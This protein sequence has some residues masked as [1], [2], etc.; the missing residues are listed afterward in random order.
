M[1]IAPVN[2]IAPLREVS[3]LIGAAIGGRLSGEQHLRS[4]LAAASIDLP[5]STGCR[6]FTPD[7]IYLFPKFQSSGSRFTAHTL[8]GF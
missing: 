2:Q 8:A 1:T 6:R 4:R 5:K 7:H 3:T